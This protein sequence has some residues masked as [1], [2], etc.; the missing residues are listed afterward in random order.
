MIWHNSRRLRLD[1]DLLL[2]LIVGGQGFR[3]QGAVVCTL[4]MF[5]ASLKTASTASP[6]DGLSGAHCSIALQRL[7]MLISAHSRPGESP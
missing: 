6:P 3:V 5:P 2:M 1:V 4:E 7:D